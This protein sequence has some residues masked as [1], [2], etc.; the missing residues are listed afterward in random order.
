MD[1]FKSNKLFFIILGILLVVFIGSIVYFVMEKNMTKKAIAEKEAK[2]GALTRLSSID[3]SKEHVKLLEAAKVDAKQ[4]YEDIVKLLVTWK[5]YNIESA[6]VS[7]IVAF[8]RDNVGYKDIKESTVRKW[9]ADKKLKSFEA[10][11]GSSYVMRPDLEAFFDEM[12]KSKGSDD[13]PQELIDALIASTEKVFISEKPAIFLSKLEDLQNQIKAFAKNKDVIIKDQAQAIYLS[14]DKY[15]MDKK[16]P[17][18]TEDLIPL[19]KQRN[20]VRDIMLLL[21]ESGVYE[22][23]SIQ[24][25]TGTSNERKS[26]FY[27]ARD[28]EVKFAATYPAIARFMNMILSPEKREV[29]FAPGM[30]DLLPRNMFV[31]TD[32][33]YKSEEAETELKRRSD[34]EQ[35][36]KSEED[37][38]KISDTFTTKTGA[39]YN[40]YEAGMMP[41]DPRFSTTGSTGETDD[42]SKYKAKMAREKK[43]TEDMVGRRPEHTVIVVTMTISF[44][45]LIGTE[46][47]G[48]PVK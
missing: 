27:V 32:I 6:G 20:A 25:L 15:L 19:I 35:K 14:F 3:P 29:T 16:P 41:K 18:A 30:T 28:F 7:D 13:I 10:P 23:H 24:Y 8:I 47:T 22:I 12:R 17:A 31:I 46:L 45:D 33:M 9:I 5:D 43:M 42:F 48:E 26:D 2:D 38:K 39:V 34:W 4:T 11:D 1:I 44:V 21:I 40:P 37:R 36:K